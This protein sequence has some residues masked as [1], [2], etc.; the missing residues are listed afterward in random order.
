VK[1]TWGLI[2][3]PIF[4]TAVIAAFSGPELGAFFTNDRNTLSEFAWYELGVGGRYDPHTPIWWI[5]LIGSLFI[6]ATVI[7]H[8]WFKV[9]D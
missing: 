8:I 1:P 2:Y 7:G 4:L 9:P 5:T 6:I 3:W